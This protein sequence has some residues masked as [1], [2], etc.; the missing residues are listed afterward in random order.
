MDALRTAACGLGFA[1][2][3]AT[4]VRP[5]RAAGVTVV[6]GVR[7][8]GPTCP[9]APVSVPSFVDAL[10]VELAGHPSG[11]GTTLVTLA[12][13]PCD[14]ATTRVRVAVTS[15]TSASAWARDVGLE[16]ITL[17]ARPRAL[18]LAVAEIVR[19]VETTFAPPPPPVAAAPPPPAN[20][21]PWFVARGAL[22]AL[23]ELFPS[24]DTTL[25]G[26][27]L[28][29]SLERPHLALALF[30]EAAAGAHGY[31][32][33][34]V[35]LQTFGGGVV[36]GPRWVS[37]RL[38]VSP[39]LVGALGWA[40]IQGHARQPDVATGAG[41]DLTVALR[42]RLEVSAVVVRF[43]SV[44]AFVEGGW[45]VRGLDAT[46]DGARAAGVSGATLLGGVGL[47]L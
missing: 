29:A 18:A 47:A 9:I 40:R 14:T 41:A 7:V 4:P 25:W 37:R 6:A 44:R 36:V 15:D 20:E 8:T 17:E 2:A 35:A 43:V 1:V 19:G 31:A 30:G 45:M 10:R 16:D 38:T 5:A 26:G 12:V 32:S 24:R 13:E 46:V 11:P 23:V 28:S 22:D 39:A 27:R 42:A 3:L 34:D 21:G 33:G